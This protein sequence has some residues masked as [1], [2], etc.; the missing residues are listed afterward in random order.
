MPTVLR[1]HGFVF[2]FYAHEPTEPPHVH[3]DRGG[4]T[5]KLWLNPVRVAWTAELKPPEVRHAVEIAEQFEDFLLEK[6]N[7]FFHR[8]NP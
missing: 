2:Y 1:R 6:W 5:V 8:A 4:G 7:E 3:V